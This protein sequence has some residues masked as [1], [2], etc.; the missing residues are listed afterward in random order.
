MLITGT[1][2]EDELFSFSSCFLYCIWEQ[3]VVSLLFLA[4]GPPHHSVQDLAWAHE[5]NCT[6]QKRLAHVE[7]D[8]VLD[9][10]L[11]LHVSGREEFI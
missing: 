11:F 7:Q 4:A 5:Q 8:A 10:L 9:P 3:C 1:V 6:S 2:V